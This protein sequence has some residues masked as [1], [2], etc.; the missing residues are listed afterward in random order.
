[1]FSL[2]YLLMSDVCVQK[3]VE[4]IDG[5]AQVSIQPG[6]H[7]GDKIV[8]EGRGTVDAT[9]VAEQEEVEEKTP[10]PKRGDHIVVVEVSLLLLMLSVFCL[11]A[12]QHT[13]R[14]SVGCVQFLTNECL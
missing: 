2:P 4:V 1:M 8:I 5:T 10:P 13:A 7:S 14:S 12:Q 9:A 6:T 11:R 3:E